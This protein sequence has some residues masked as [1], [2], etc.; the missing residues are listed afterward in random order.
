MIFENIDEALVALMERTNT[1]TT[2][3]L[4]PLKALINRLGN[5]QDQLKM[6]HIAGTNGKGSTTDYL[7]SIYQHAGYKVASF[8]SPHLVSHHDRFRINNVPISDEKLLFYINKSLPY[9]DEYRLSMFEIDMVISLWY[10]VEEKVDLVLYEVG[11]GGLLDAT[12]VI[13]PIASVITNIGFDHMHILGD[14]LE[15][16]AM[17]KAG[18]I[19]ESGLVFTGEKRPELISLFEHKAQRRVYRPQMVEEVKIEPLGLSYRY[20]NQ[21]IQLSTLA[22][23]QVNNSSLAF[24]VAYQLSKHNDI[25]VSDEVILLGLQDTFW[26]G[27]FEKMSDDPLIYIDG[28]HNIMGIDELVKTIKQFKTKCTVVF[29]A[30]KDKKYSLMI[31]RL[32]EISDEIIVTEF[33][34]YRAT[35]LEDLARG[36]NVVA[37]EN[38]EEAIEYAIKNH[39]HFVVITGSLYFISDVRGYLQKRR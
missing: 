5:P 31:D 15:E 14:T 35:K 16:I 7:R 37:I 20:R 6:I 39:K 25:S 1:L 30:V 38:Y 19:K 34:F 24:E 29:S 4:D 23:Y 18:I 32:E 27:R 33:D 17:Q 28:A 11:L 3:K 21:K 8:T 2:Y 12:N 13:T 9:W 10:F 26:L 36:H 22:Q